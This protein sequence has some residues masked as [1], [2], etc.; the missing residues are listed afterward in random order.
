MQSQQ[1]FCVFVGLP[2]GASGWSQWR[3]W[4]GAL[5]VVCQRLTTSHAYVYTTPRI[6]CAISEALNSSYLEEREKWPKAK[7]SPLI[8]AVRPRL[9]C[10][11]ECP[12][13]L[14]MN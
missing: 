7:E 5:L 6:H 8:A 10:E 13:N 4:G 2:R 11:L 3:S 1:C 12:Q 9:C 14:A